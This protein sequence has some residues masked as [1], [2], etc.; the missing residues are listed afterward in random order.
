M[1]TFLLAPFAAATACLAQV[2]DAPTTS[3]PTVASTLPATPHLLLDTVGPDGWRTRLGPTNLGSLLASEQGRALWQPSVLPMLGQ[4]KAMLGGDEA[5]TAAEQRLLGHQGRI[6]IGVWLDLEARNAGDAMA[7]ATLIEGDGRTDLPSLA[8]DLHKLLAMAIGGDE[9]KLELAGAPREVRRQDG[10]A[11][12]LP[13]VA[14]NHVLLAVGPEPLVPVVFAAMQKL[15]ADATGKPP[16]PNT[17]ALR[18]QLDLAPLIANTIAKEGARDARM[19]KGLG[20]P[21][22]GLLAMSVAAAGPHVQFELAQQFTSDDRGLFAALLPATAG[23]PATHGLV[24]T[25]AASWKVGRFDFHGLYRAAITA[26][27]S[28]QEQTPGE[29]TEDLRKECGIDPDTELLAHTTDEMLLWHAPL[30]ELDRIERTD[31]TLA[32][33]LRDRDAFAKGLT[34]LL[35]HGKPMLM[36]E[37]AVTVDGVELLRYGSFGYDLWLAV[38]PKHFVLAGGKGAQANVEALLRAAKS[39]PADAPAAKALADLQRHLPPGC[40]GHARSEIGG[41]AALPVAWWTMALREFVPM[42]PFGG[43][44]AEEDDE[45]RNQRRELLKAHQLDVVRTATGYA[46]RTWRWRLWW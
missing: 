23:V 5:G 28:M 44:G 4:V 34:T 9:G 19:M 32:I 16:L 7:M 11:F 20:L 27:A 2:P 31:W 24:P 17:P 37:E 41:F 29:L 33:G 45:A 12:V 3:A 15:G 35:Q 42:V 21:S 46:E 36:R 39:A 43:E 22:L 30:D 13:F 40:N 6:R 8:S 18:L 14:G 38:G 10:A 25:T 26:I 1:K